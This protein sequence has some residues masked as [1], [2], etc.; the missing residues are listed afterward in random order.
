MDGMELKMEMDRNNCHFQS[1]QA[2]NPHLLATI[3]ELKR[4]IK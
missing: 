4:M 3:K 2:K 1:L